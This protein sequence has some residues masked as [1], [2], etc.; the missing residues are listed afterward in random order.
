MA[1]KDA[2]NKVDGT[3]VL[4]WKKVRKEIDGKLSWARIVK[5]RLTARGFKDM[6]TFAEHNK[7]YSG[8]ATKW[9]QRAINGHAGQMGYTLFSMGITADFLKGMTSEEI[10]R[11]TGEPLRH[12]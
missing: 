10:A 9:A 11:L 2:R 1:R 4:K 5:A 6:Q 8:T 3:W 7:T 12:V